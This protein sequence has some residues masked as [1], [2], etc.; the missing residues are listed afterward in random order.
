M[1]YVAG[2]LQ[3]SLELVVDRVEVTA[4]ITVTAYHTGIDIIVPVNQL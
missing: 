2:L 1:V 4:I 3:W